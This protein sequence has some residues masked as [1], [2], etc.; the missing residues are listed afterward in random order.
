MGAISHSERDS[1][2]NNSRARLKAIRMK[3][4]CIRTAKLKRSKKAGSTE[5]A[6]R[7]NGI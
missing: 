1:L 3:E 4:V 2:H 5:I 6:L 7:A